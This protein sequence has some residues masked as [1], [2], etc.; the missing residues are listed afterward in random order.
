MN[1]EYDERVKA[2]TG[3]EPAPRDLRE[4]TTC[5]QKGHYYYE[6]NDGAFLKMA[7]ALAIGLGGRSDNGSGSV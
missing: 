1:S 4:C 3:F 5:G 6:C 7:D 2:L